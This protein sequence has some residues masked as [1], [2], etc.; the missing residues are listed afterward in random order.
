MKPQGPIASPCND[1]CRID[2]ASGWCLGCGRS[3]DEIAAWA[4][5]S[6]DERRAVLAQLPSRRL[7]LQPAQSVIGREQERVR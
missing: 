7:R 2:A 4:S 6:D 5:A 3:I 1:V